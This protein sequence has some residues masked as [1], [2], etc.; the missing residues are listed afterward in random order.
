MSNIETN[1]PTDEEMAVCF[2]TKRKC[3]RKC[4]MKVYC[5]DEAKEK[6][7]DVRRRQFRETPFLDEM[8][9]ESDDHH[10]NREYL[11]RQEQQDEDVS[12]GE[13][14]RAI[15]M[16]DV[17]D[18]VR[19]GLKKLCRRREEEER[20]RDETKEMLSRLG[21][22][23]VFDP[24][25]FEALFFQVLSGCNQSTLAKMHQC[26]K[27][28]ISKKMNKG[29]ERL[30]AHRE[31]KLN[32]KTM[33]SRELA[34][35]YYVFVEKKSRRE[36]AR[37][38]GLGKST[39]AEIAEKLTKAKFAPDKKTHIPRAVKIFRKK[40]AGEE[41]SDVEKAIYQDIMNGEKSVRSLAKRYKCSVSIIVSLRKLKNGRT[42]NASC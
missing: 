10:A 21:E 13:I 34:V 3:N 36:T 14:I 38:L 1:E 6:T 12:S 17:P 27:Q 30:A 40:T 5:A 7:E 4:R 16:L 29:K 20:R 42:K 23:Y 37:V 8:D 31:R 28:N 32:G 33:T 41:L 39:V 18:H 22:L 19:E 9:S 15:E 26:T 2:G 25:G 35:Y 11:A 24:T